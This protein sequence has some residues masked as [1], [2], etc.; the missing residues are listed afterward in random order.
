MFLLLLSKAFFRGTRFTLADTALGAFCR[1]F[2]PVRYHDFSARY[3]KKDAPF[4]TPF[5]MNPRFLEFPE[6]TWGNSGTETGT[7]RENPC[8]VPE[9]G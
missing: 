1:I 2:L 9:T 3:C 8:R 7:R 4:S 6:H 5:G